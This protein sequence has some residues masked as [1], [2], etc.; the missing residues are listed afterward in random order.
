MKSLLWKLSID[1]MYNL[2][3]K[4]EYDENIDNLCIE[5]MKHLISCLD[6]YLDDISN[7]SAADDIYL[8]IYANG[9]LENGEIIY[10]ISKFYDYIRFSDVAIT[11]GDI[12]YLIDNGLYYSK[13]NF[14][15]KI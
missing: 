5:G 7:A 15:F 8:R 2:Q 13:V 1:E 3:Q 14:Y 9:T 12:D 10:A 6:V 11:M 4:F